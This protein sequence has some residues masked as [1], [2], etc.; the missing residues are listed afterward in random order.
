MKESVN[1]I[2]LTIRFLPVTRDL[3]RNLIAAVEDLQG[4]HLTIADGQGEEHKKR[5]ILSKT[6]DIASQGKFTYI[7]GRDFSERTWIALQRETE[8]IFSVADDDNISINLIRALYEAVQVAAP[9]ISAIAPYTYMPF[10]KNNAWLRRLV[11]ITGETQQQRITAL[12]NQLPII[13]SLIWSAVRRE[14]Y[15]DWVKFTR[16]KQM[17]PTYLDQVLVA[18][19]TMRGKVVACKEVCLYVKDDQVWC[20]LESSVIKDASYYPDISVTLIHEVLMVADIYAFLTAHGLEDDALIRLTVWTNSLLIRAAALFDGR[21]SIL[22]IE[23]S[24]E[25]ELVRAL[26]YQLAAT[27]KLLADKPINQYHA[28]YGWVQSVCAVLTAA[29]REA[30]HRIPA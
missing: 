1:I 18:Y 21:C 24:K 20:E 25:R 2:L 16:A 23:Q 22:G 3:I 12:L 28:F 19:L 11:D 8:W 5:W 9:D 26:L 15:L 30:V 10:S 7:E 4:V 17:A 13:G 27:A 6:G 14:Y 29:P